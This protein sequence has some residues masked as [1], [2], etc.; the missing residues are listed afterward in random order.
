M[1]VSNSYKHVFG[2]YWKEVDDRITELIIKHT[3][4]TD[5]VLEAG[6]ASGHYLAYLTDLGINVSGIEI[7]EEAYSK[8][9][10]SFED[11]Y[12]QIQ[13]YCGDVMHLHTEYDF[14]YSTGLIQCLPPKERNDFL[15]HISTIADKIM[16]TVPKLGEVRNAFSDEKVAV[17]GCKEYPT[18][19]IAYQLSLLYGYVECGTWGKDDIKLDDDFQWFYCDN[20]RNIAK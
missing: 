7:R 14:I 16:Y 2:N 13:L 11:V 5:R 18:G 8:T 19:D 6:F 15:Y 12:P 10:L 20:S 9:K 3:D 1:A 17:A 4:T